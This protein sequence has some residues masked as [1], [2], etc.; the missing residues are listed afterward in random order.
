M[1]FVNFRPWGELDWLLPKISEERWDL[2][3]C[4]ST[5]D[6]S[7][8]ALEVLTKL[9]RL[10]NNAFLKVWDPPSEFS[11][12]IKD[13]LAFIEKEYLKLVGTRH[14]VHERYLLCANSD[15][16]SFINSFLD[17]NAPNVVID[18][19]CLPKRFFFP[20]LKIALN[21]ENVRNL[22]VTYSTA[23][24][25]ADKLSEDPEPWEHLPLFGPIDYPEPTPK[26]AIIGI[27]FIPFGLS[28]LLKDK[29]SSIPVT[30]FFPF[31]PGPPFYQRSWEFL[32]NIEDKY[33]FKPE[34][35]LVR[36]NSVDVS[37]VYNH[38]KSITNEG[39]EPAIFAPYGP[40]P[41]SIGIAIYSALSKSPVYYT[42]PKK[43]SPE[44]SSGKGS[45]F[46]YL[47]KKEGNILYE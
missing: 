33:S 2:C 34:D 42:Q 37:D 18:I 5:E 27:G 3:G 43:Y 13:R 28:K 41:I 1:S 20:F 29:Y 23:L 26:H 46:A 19:S 16:V 45:V 39:N 21:D 30:F 12:K 11:G 47:L 44:Y 35:N 36:V 32:R 31:P 6:R 14:N 38:I 24:S 9:R 15:I 8:L 10:D 7:T 25:Y 22:V 17:R 40:K 4:I